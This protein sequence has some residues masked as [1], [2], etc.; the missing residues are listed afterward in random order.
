MYCMT[1][2]VSNS[3]STINNILISVDNSNFASVLFKQAYYA[4]PGADIN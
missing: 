2:S 4:N 3:F 1:Y